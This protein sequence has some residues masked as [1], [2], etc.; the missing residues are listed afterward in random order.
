MV[1]IFWYWCYQSHT[2]QDSVY[3]VCRIF[4]SIFLFV[5]W[6]GF[7]SCLQIPARK[8]VW[9]WEKTSDRGRWRPWWVSRRCSGDGEVGGPI[10]HNSR[11]MTTRRAMCLLLHGRH[12]CGDTTFN[13]TPPHTGRSTQHTIQYILHTIKCTMHTIQC[14]MY[15]IW[16]LLYSARQFDHTKLNYSGAFLT[17]YFAR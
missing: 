11:L 13:F 2:L 16:C 14:T 15:T 5:A 9:R 1:Y 3:P 12:T 17:V 7:S 8:S 10:R 4:Y 6:Q